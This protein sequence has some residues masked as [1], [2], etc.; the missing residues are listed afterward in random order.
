MIL[1]FTLTMP[2]VGSWNGKWS[3]EGDFYAVT[4][5]FNK[6]DLDKAKKIL[7]EGSY[8]YRWDDGWGANVLVKQID[9]KE[10]QKVK[11]KSK[12]FRGYDWMVSSIIEHG[13]IKT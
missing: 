13:F 8:Y 1:Q 11:R 4:R 12:G 9:S 10:S 3:G 2:N 5:K 7:A 6:T